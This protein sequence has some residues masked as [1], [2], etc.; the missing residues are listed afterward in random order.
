MA[1]KDNDINLN[2]TE[3]EFMNRFQKLCH[4]RQS[5]EVWAD[6]VNMFARSYSNFPESVAVADPEQR[7]ERWKKREKEYLHLIGKYPK[8]E[9]KLFP[10]MHALMVTELERRRGDFLGDMYMKLNLGSH[11][12]GQFF[13]PQ[14]VASLMAEITVPKESVKAEIEEKGFISIC[15]PACGAG[16]NLLA[17][18]HSMT[19]AD[20]NY[21]EKAMFAGQDID[22]IAGLM[23]YVQLCAFGCAGYVCIADTLVNPMTGNDPLLVVE[24]PD[25]EWW[26]TPAWFTPIWAGRRTAHQMDIV[27]RRTGKELRTVPGSTFTFNFQNGA[28]SYG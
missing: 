5:W 23:C 22:S 2:N 8:D 13:T 15:D 17:A 11:W 27:I 24:K 18:V 12:H 21:Q 4:T 1:K 14:S 28:V 26:Y 10:E 3:K 19:L 20:I 7:S 16:V 9:Q 25:Q 6:M